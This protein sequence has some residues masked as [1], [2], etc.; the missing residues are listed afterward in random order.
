M[1][2]SDVDG[3]FQTEAPMHIQTRPPQGSVY[4]LFLTVTHIR[5]N[6]FDQNIALDFRLEVPQ[7]AA[8]IS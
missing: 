4:L 8:Y 6:C 7:R 3:S 1:L 5:K 2:L